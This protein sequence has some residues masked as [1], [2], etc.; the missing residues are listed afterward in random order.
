MAFCETSSNWTVLTL[1]RIVWMQ[2]EQVHQ[3]FFRDLRDANFTPDIIADLR[4]EVEQSVA[5]P[6]HELSVGAKRRADRLLLLFID[7]SES[8]VRF[9]PGGPFFGFWNVVLMRIAQS[10]SRAVPE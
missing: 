3:A 8:M 7:G 4:S 10:R 9:E 5:T 2:G 6:S 1:S